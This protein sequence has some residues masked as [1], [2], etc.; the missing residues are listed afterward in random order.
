[1][2]TYHLHSPMLVTRSEY[3][4]TC[5]HGWYKQRKSTLSDGGV[6][7][8]GTDEING[9]PV[10]AFTEHVTEEELDA[11]DALLKFCYS[12]TFGAHCAQTLFDIMILADK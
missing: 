12:G 2:R 5:I 4:K 11:M 1:M 7:Y 9:R 6:R 3:F 10:P 8:A